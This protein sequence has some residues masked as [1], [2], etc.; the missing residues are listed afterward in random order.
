MM[1]AVRTYET[2]VSFVTTWCYIPEDSKLVIHFVGFCK[3]MMSNEERL[4]SDVTCADEY[5]ADVMHVNIKQEP[6]VEEEYQVCTRVT[7]NW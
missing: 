4:L 5:N 1:E 6:H 3:P 7:V 2:L